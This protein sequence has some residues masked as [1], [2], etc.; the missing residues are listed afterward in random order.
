MN[1]KLTQDLSKHRLVV[2]ILLLTHARRI[3]V[4]A[5][6]MRKTH[7]LIHRILTLAAAAVAR[8]KSPYRRWRRWRNWVLGAEAAE[9]LEDEDMFTED[10]E[11]NLFAEELCVEGAECAK[12]MMVEDEA[13]AAT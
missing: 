13:G 9:H 2:V 8:K 5:A 6:V 3:L 11:N 7:P 12:V 4:L 10:A 1:T